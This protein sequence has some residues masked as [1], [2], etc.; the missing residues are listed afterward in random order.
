VI[1]NKIGGRLIYTEE[2]LG[3]HLKRSDASPNKLLRDEPQPGDVFV[4]QMAVST[5]T[6]R[7][8]QQT[9]EQFRQVRDAEI[10]RI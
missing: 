8:N 9:E 1:V 4:R 7:C 5:Q 3:M 6:I 2:L 10:S